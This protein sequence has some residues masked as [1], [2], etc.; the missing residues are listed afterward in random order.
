MESTVISINGKKIGCPV[1]T[2]VL[3]A[4][5][6][7]GIHIPRLC[8]HPELKPHGACRMCLVEDEKSGRLLASCVTPVSGGMSVQTDSKAVLRHRRNIVRLMISEHPESCV[9]CS[10]GNR[11]Q[12][13]R[14]A[15]EL[16]VGE[17]ELYPMPHVNALDQSNPF[18]VRDLSKCILCGRCIRGCKEL[19]AQG[20]IDYSLRG[21]DS[22]P[23][24]LHDHPLTESSCTFCGTCVSLCPTGALS[25]KKSAFSGTPE[26]EH[27]TICG[28][29]GVGCSLSLGVF[30]SRVVE[31][32]PARSRESVNGVTLCVRGHFAHDYLNSTHRLLRPR[33]RKGGEQA[34][35]PWDE[36]VSAVSEKLL[37]IRDKHG[38]SAIG[39][40]GSSTCTNEENYLFQKMARGILGTHNIDNGG[41]FCGRNRLDDFFR[42]TRGIIGPA[43]FFDMETADVIVM[44]GADQGETIPVAS[45][46]VKRAA[47]NGVPLIVVDSLAS[48]FTSL[49]TLWLRPLP[50]SGHL[51]QVMHALSGLVLSHSNTHRDGI[52]GSTDNLGDFERDVSRLDMETMCRTAG[53]D[54]EMLK[55]AAGIIAGRRVVLVAGCEVLEADDGGSALNALIN[56]ALVSGDPGR[57][58][59]GVWFSIRE[60]NLLGAWAMG[61]DFSPDAGLSMVGMIEAAEKGDL[62]VLY[63][64][65]E[66]PLRAM[67]Q[68]Q[69]VKAALENLE[70][71]VVQDILETETVNIAD[72][73][74]PG[75]APAEKAGSFTNME[76]RVQSFTPAVPPPGEAKADLD[77]LGLVAKGLGYRGDDLGLEA[78]RAEIKRLVPSW[79]R[80]ESPAENHGDDARISFQPIACA[81]GT[82]DPAYPF[83][84]IAGSR[85]LHAGS[86]TRTSHSER[87]RAAGE[88]GAM[89][90]SEADAGMLGLREGDPV[91]IESRHGAIERC[92]TIT[93]DMAK[94]AV[95]I[96]RGFLGN[97][98]MN[99]FPLSQAGDMWGMS[100]G[101]RIERVNS[102]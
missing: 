32:S 38:A 54:V 71:V 82:D 55:E 35:V 62:K 101:V 90:I 89:E 68:Q 37:E 15:A 99:L 39:F 93:S 78:V 52:A 21:V 63:I 20:T 84:M 73:V 6:S 76:G 69:R 9:V 64:M 100:C 22:R 25:Q 29:C 67:P 98:V 41:V 53:L 47:R 11:C 28:F 8:Y 102:E 12:L 19:V 96:P 86:G 94:G 88:G 43:R 2:S 60:N 27:D 33:L 81:E 3:E 13:R 26:R 46:H 91:R 18:I 40:L 23:A 14:V 72:V 58:P 61:T 30:G 83:M 4:A 65:G 79:T 70:L 1:G 66:N 34:S 17:P 92:V 51:G 24:T 59:A 48:D 80:D 36:A 5:D 85:R 95:L 74:L 45:Y 10:K 75:A 56:L 49:S 77:I 87:T 31:V 97:D 7:A 42:K 44:A 16:G 50:G 57:S